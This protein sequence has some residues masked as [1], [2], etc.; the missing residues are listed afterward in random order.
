[1]AESLTIFYTRGLGGDY[2]L[3]ARLGRW[4]RQLRAE[5]GAGSRAL[6]LDLGQASDQHSWHHRRTG[7]RDTL[8][9]LEALGYHAINAAGTLNLPVPANLRA[10]FRLAIITPEMDWRDERGERPIRCALHSPAQAAAGEALC[11]AL[12]PTEESELRAGVLR[13]AP[14][15]AGCV[16]RARLW[17]SEEGPQLL[18]SATHPLPDELAPEPSITAT[19]E[20]VLAEARQLAA[21][22]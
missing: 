4:L 5:Y 10:A 2:A 16:G 20:L 14:V 7:G 19:V 15:A 1:M 13:L 17:L 8:F 3:A 18:E 9:V 12:T 21:R 11:V 6:L 22:A